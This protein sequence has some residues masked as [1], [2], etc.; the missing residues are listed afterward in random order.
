MATTAAA[1]PASTPPLAANAS[2]TLDASQTATVTIANNDAAIVRGSP[3]AIATSK[4]AD[5]VFADQ[6]C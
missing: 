4:I 6:F 3:I 1:I 5:G 2:Y